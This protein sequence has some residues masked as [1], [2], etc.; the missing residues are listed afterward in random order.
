[1]QASNETAKMAARVQGFGARV[2]AASAAATPPDSKAGMVGL[3]Q[4]QA[5][6][7]SVLKV[8]RAENDKIQIFNKKGGH[9]SVLTMFLV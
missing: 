8:Q 3:Q 7:R 2:H 9:R 1:M 5:D 4:V 6:H